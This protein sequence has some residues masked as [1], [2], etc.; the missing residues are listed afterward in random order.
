MYLHNALLLTYYTKTP[1]PLLRHYFTM[2]YV[3]LLPAHSYPVK[4]A[5]YLSFVTTGEDLR[6]KV[7]CSVNE[8]LAVTCS[9]IYLP[10]R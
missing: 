9:K 6:I 10:L 7:S 5:P 8:S 3:T 1:T 2:Y 4:V